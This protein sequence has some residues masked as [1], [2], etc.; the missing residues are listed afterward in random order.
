MQTYVTDYLDGKKVPYRLKRHQRPVFTSEEAAAQ[1]GVRLS[2]IVK[3]MLLSN[4]KG[5]TVVAILP[6]HKR[7]DAKELRKKAGVKDLQF[8]DRK[9][10]EEQTSMVVG[11]IAPVGGPLQGL[12]MFVDPDVFAETLVD[13]SSGDPSAGVELKSADLKQL[14]SHATVAV[15]SK[16]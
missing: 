13:I 5:Q 9:A 1:R 7:L 3:T 16:E 11:A 12:P 8:M 14:L 2:Q 4:K 10:I 6:G 15:I